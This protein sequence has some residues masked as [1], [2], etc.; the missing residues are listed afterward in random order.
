MCKILWE[1]HD[2]SF[3]ARSSPTDVL[4]AEN[5]VWKIHNKRPY[6]LHTCSI[7][8]ALSLIKTCKKE[9]LDVKEPTS[10]HYNLT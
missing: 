10:E 8:P 1:V 5:L 3:R 7:N 6:P 2:F 9:N 4:P